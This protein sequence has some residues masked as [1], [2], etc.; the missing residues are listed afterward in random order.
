[1]S[2]K[3]IIVCACGCGRTGPVHARLL[4]RKCYDTYQRR[5]VHTRY[6][7]E[8]GEMRPKPLALQGKG[9]TQRVAE[10]AD[11]LAD[12]LRKEEIAIQLGVTYRTVCRYAAHLAYIEETDD[13]Q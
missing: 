4:I 11:M 7:R 1:M 10:C 3:R 5:K 6:P 8:R 12:G 9:V 2:E 13:D